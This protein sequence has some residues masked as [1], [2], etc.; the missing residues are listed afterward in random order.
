MRVL[1][2]TR[3]VPANARGGDEFV[4]LDTLFCRSDVVSL[5]CPLTPQTH[6][7]VN[8]G[9][10]A[11]MKSTAFLINTGRGSL[12]DE[13]A[14]AA[15]LNSGRLAG[16]AMDVL[17]VEP[18]PSNH[19]LLTARNCLITPHH[20]WATRAA[21]QRLLRETVENLRAFLAGQPRNVVNG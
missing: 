4:D 1:V 14:L 12:V 19:P 18:P 7:L 9:R 17:S 5:H 13:P 21:R 3:T 16:A 2:R 11:C 8:A 10:L 6:H 20:A 15:A